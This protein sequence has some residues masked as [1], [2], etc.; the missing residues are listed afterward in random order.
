MRFSV[1]FETVTPESAEHGDTADAGFV[2]QGVG[3]RAALDEFGYWADGGIEASCSD[4]EDARWL[5]AYRTREDFATGEVENRS[6]HFPD[7]MTGASRRRLARLL[8]C[9]GVR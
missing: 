7:A 3:L 9:L 2:V 4:I 1:T 8:G 6:I 5:T